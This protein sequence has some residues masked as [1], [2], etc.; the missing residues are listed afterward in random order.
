MS[1]IPVT[2]G[3][4][5]WVG[6]SVDE[7]DAGNVTATAVF[8]VFDSDGSSVQAESEA[9]ITG[10]GTALVY[11]EGLVDTTV[12]AFVAGDPYEVMFTVTIDS[13][14]RIGKRHIRCVEARL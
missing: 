13:A 6:V 5:R 8:E 7:R 9:T 11:A 1:E 10:S 4:K 2:K 12:S 14:V 3:E